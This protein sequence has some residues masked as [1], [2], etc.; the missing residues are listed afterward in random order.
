M[1]FPCHSRFCVVFASFLTVVFLRLFSPSFVAAVFASFPSVLLPLR[2]PPPSLRFARASFPI[3]FLLF[4]TLVFPHSPLIFTSHFLHIR[5]LRTLAFSISPVCA[6]L[7]SHSLSPLPNPH[8][9]APPEPLFSLHSCTSRT[10]FS[11]RFSPLSTSR[12]TVIFPCEKSSRFAAFF[13]G[14]LIDRLKT[15]GI[16]RRNWGFNRLTNKQLLFS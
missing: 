8:S 5:T 7:N 11:L 6:G 9:P 10:R 13:Q 12:F 1:L 2:F 4:R 3:R 16:S 14:Q 15:T